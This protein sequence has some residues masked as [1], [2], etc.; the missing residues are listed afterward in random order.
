MSE[1]RFAPLPAHFD[2]EDGATLR[3]LAWLAR[4]AYYDV[5]RLPAELAR[6]DQRLT[7]FIDVD[8]TAGFFSAGE[9]AHV[10]AF[11]GTE[12]DEL[13]DIVT[14]LRVKPTA[15]G[16]GTAHS[17]FV[18]AVTGALEAIHAGLPSAPIWIVGHSLGGALAQVLAA[19]L[20]HPMAAVVSFGSPRVGDPAFGQGLAD[21]LGPLLLRVTHD[22]DPVPDFPPKPIGYR[23]VGP[24]L[25]LIE[26]GAVERRGG[27]EDDGPPTFEEI[28]RGKAKLHLIPHYEALIEA[29]FS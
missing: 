14:D 28:V 18:A 16:S 1:K 7:T 25:R 2:P 15:Y 6:V 9:H 22:R 26:G 4:C 8:G 29:A 19:T 23:H 10:L 17:G 24:E 5:D 20:E 3:S 13:R 11:R 21:L 27:V 12:F